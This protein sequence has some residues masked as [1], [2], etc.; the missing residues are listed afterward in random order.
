MYSSAFDFWSS[1]VIQPIAKSSYENKVFA[2]K[3]VTNSNNGRFQISFDRFL[4]KRIV[5]EDAEV[6][7]CSTFNDPP[8]YTA[9]SDHCDIGIEPY[10]MH[11]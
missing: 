2:Q 6:T 11:V 5:Y 10:F 4:K 7:M 3:M 1:T 9:A 8:S